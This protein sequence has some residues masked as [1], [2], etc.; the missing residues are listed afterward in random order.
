[1]APM[2]AEQCQHR[3]YIRSDAG[4]ELRQ[5]MLAGAIHGAQQIILDWADVVLESVGARAHAQL[6]SSPEDAT[7]FPNEKLTTPAKSGRGDL[8][9]GSESNRAMI[10]DSQVP[11]PDHVFQVTR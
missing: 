3:S 4:N 6:S 1:M 9:S 7:Q 11:P 8:H 2:V 10:R 5:P